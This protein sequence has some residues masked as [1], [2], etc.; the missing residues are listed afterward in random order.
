MLRNQC[1][2]D[3]CAQWELQMHFQHPVKFTVIFMFCYNTFQGAWSMHDCRLT[4]IL[5]IISLGR[6]AYLPA[7]GWSP[8]AKTRV[9]TCVARYTET[10]GLSPILQHEKRF[11]TIISVTVGTSVK[12]VS[13]FNSPSVQPMSTLLKCES[14]LPAPL[15]FRLHW[16]SG[17]HHVSSPLMLHRS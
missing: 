9:D 10:S 17:R 6:L 16:E 8:C 12:C 5:T 2:I 4:N 15:D 11:R 14:T 13:R 3:I 1:G 7:V